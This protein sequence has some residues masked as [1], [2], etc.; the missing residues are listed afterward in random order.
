LQNQDIA[1]IFYEIADIL[2]M[3][4]E[5]SFRIRSYR[6]AASAIEN[7]TED[8]TSIHKKGALKE[9]PGI[10]ESI[11]QKIEEMINTGKC[12]FHH[13][14]LKKIPPGVLDIMRVPGMGPRHAMLVYEKL[15]VNS[16]DRL[17]R[18]AQAGKLQDLPRMGAKLQQKI[19]RGIEQLVASEG[20]FKLITAYTYAEA[21]IKE[22]KK[23]KGVER[24]EVAGSVRRKKE[25][26]GDLDIL[27]ISASPRGVMDAFVKLDDIKEVLAKG[28]TKSSAVLRCG[29]QVDVRVLEKENF[30]AALYYFTGSK[31]HNIV[32]RD[33]VKKRGLKINE[34]GVFRGKKRIAGKTEEGIF[35]AMGLSYIEPELRENTGEIEAA[36]RGR[37]PHLLEEDDLRGDFHMHTK[38]SDGKDAIEEMVRKARA[39]GYEYIAITEHSK[40]VTVAHGRDEK[41]LLRHFARID[42][43]NSRLGGFKILKGV[44]VDIKSDGSLDLEDYFLKQCDVVIAA[45]H[46]RFEMPKDQMTR[47][48]TTAL[49]NKNVDIFAHPTGRLLKERPAY[50]VDMDQVLQTAKD[51]N[52]AMELSAYPDRLDL[53]DIHCRLAKS[54]GVKIAIGTDSH[55]ASQL[56]NMRWGVYTARR[57]WLEKKDVLNTLPLEKLLKNFKK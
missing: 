53:N 49:Q 25:M 7:L 16:I 47:R 56:D 50:A 11:A 8:L 32:V 14:L 13:A 2:E 20:R 1:Q 57:G 45:I 4:G 48:I 43:V 39:K 3:Q 23:I 52:V 12:K 26:I 42:K 35:K 18:A 6:N 37:L 33:M 38:E 36:R 34:Y 40:A 9:I 5:N 31:E 55:S 30:G 46:S 28:A 22:L 15:A 29:L 54:A 51:Y 19:L 10:G 21:I 41:E 27:V 17:R 24:I 44:E